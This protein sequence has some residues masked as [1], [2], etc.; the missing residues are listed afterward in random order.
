MSA[1]QH[2]PFA[3]KAVTPAAPAEPT[4]RIRVTL[5]SCDVK[6]LEKMCRMLLQ[7]AKKENL[8][9]KGP[10]RM[11]TKTLKITCRKTPCGEGS[12]TWDRYEMRIH[13]RLLDL[14][15]TISAVRRITNIQIESGVEIEVT[16]D[17]SE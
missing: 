10:I 17:E 13:K 16:F 15:C 1:T 3:K 14:E 9:P 7:A 11:P 12:K 5:T 8:K 6:V 2:I 4:H